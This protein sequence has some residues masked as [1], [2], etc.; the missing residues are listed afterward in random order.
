MATQE[1]SEGIAP[2]H[3]IL[4]NEGSRPGINEVC[5]APRF[6]ACAQN[7]TVPS[8]HAADTSMKKR[9]LR[10]IGAAAVLV[11]LLAGCSSSPEAA[12]V[13]GEVGAD[14]GNHANPVVLLAPPDRFDRVFY[15]D[16]KDDYDNLY[17]SPAA[18]KDT[19]QP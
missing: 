12:R 6:L 13:R 17:G 4:R 5:G 18:S 1:Q 8:T 7:D 3:V 2:G 16:P 19:S 14:P 11:V 15:D 9:R 10:L